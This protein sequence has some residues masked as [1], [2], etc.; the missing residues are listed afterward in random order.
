[1]RLMAEHELGGGAQSEE[2]GSNDVKRQQLHNN[3]KSG[4]RL[5]GCH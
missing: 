4:H 2:A 5:D 1:M 3:H